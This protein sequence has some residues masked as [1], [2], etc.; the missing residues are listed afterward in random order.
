MKQVFHARKR[1]QLR[2]RIK[3]LKF[4]LKDNRSDIQFQI[5]PLIKKIKA[6]VKELSGVLAPVYLKKMLGSAAVILGMTFGSQL[7]A[8]SF[9]APQQNPFGLVSVSENDI[10]SPG[11]F[12]DFDGDGDIDLLVANYIYYSGMEIQYFEN[13]GTSTNPEFDTPQ[14]NPFGLTP[15]PDAII[16]PSV[17]DVDGDGDFDLLFP[18]SDNNTYAASFK[19][20]ENVGNAT[21]PQFAAAI[22]NPYG[23]NPVSEE[24]LFPALVD[25]DGDGDVDLVAFDYYGDAYYFENTGTS[26]D[27]QFTAQV[28]NPFGLGTAEYYLFPAFAD[29][30][31]DG[32]LDLLGGTYYANFQ[33]F[34]NTGSA[35]NPMFTAPVQNPFGLVVTQD[36]AVPAFADL[37]ADGDMDLLVAEEYGNFQYFENTSPVAVHQEY[38]NIP[39]D[40][41]PNPVIDM[42][43]IKTAALFDKIEVYDATGKL[44]NVYDGSV[45]SIDVRTWPKGM[46]LLK[47]IDERGQFSA[48]KILKE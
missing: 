20:F 12:A 42:L 19:Y 24:T 32:D 39:L 43:T 8:Q 13:I 3:R 45:N 30:D 35:N 28:Q 29:L 14:V 33:Y 1:R 31:N 36:Y 25:L 47:F 7:A 27:P 6:L 44:I 21:N 16:L 26:T 40:L 11:A 4:L 5:E 15:E 34:E 48:R 22:K 41:F 17:A 9:A 18:A 38:T 2:Y 23:L 37:D 10:P 46:Y